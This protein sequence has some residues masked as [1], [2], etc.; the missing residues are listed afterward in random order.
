MATKDRRREVRLTTADDD[1]LIEAAGLAGVSVSEFLLDRALSDAES[2]V[3]SHRTIRLG[4]AAY[5][6]FLDA[7]DA[8]LRSSE[9]LVA[10]ARRAR[11]LKRID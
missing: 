10:Q 4:P 9:D 2:I 11:R 3:Q 1:L 7:L 8:P 5:E 6:R